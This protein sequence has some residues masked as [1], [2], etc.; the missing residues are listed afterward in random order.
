MTGRKLMPDRE[1]QGGEGS[2]PGQ[3]EKGEAGPERGGEAGCE[4]ASTLP[5]SRAGLNVQEI[6]VNS[7]HQGSF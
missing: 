2:S 6:S 5:Q 4:E 3:P 7:V 1:R